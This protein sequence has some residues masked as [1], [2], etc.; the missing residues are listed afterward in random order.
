M[1]S[2]AFQGPPA[3]PPEDDQGLLPDVHRWWAMTGVGLAVLMATIDTSIVNIALPTLVAELKTDFAT[4][5]WVVLSYTLVLTSLMLAA[6]RLGDLKGVKGPYMAGLAVF[7]LGSLLCG[8]APSVHWLIAFRAFQ[9]LGAVLAQSLSMAIVTLVFPASQRGRALGVVGGMV[10]S[11]LA[12]GPPLGGVLIGFFGW[13]AVFMVNL[14]LGFLA[15]FLVL[16]F[17]PQS[18]PGEAGQRFDLA[19]ALILMASLVCYALGMTMGQL[20]GFT[21]VHVLGLIALGA[22]GMVAFIRLEWV[23]AEPMVD[24]TLFRDPL[25]SANL[26]M[27]LL[28]FVQLG[29]A[30]VIPFYLEL[31]QGYS[32]EKAGLMLMVVPV[33]MGLVS[34]WAGW[35]SDRYG[36]RGISILGLAVL[37]LGALAVTTLQ[38]GVSVWGYLLRLTPLGL[39]MGL[40]QSPNNSAIMGRV[41]RQHLGVASGLLS[42]SRTLGNTSGLPLMG[43]VFS[44]QVLASAHLPA[45]SAITQ[46]PASALVAGLHGTY[47]VAALMALAAMCLAIWAWWQDRQESGVVD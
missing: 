9:G 3:A 25:F 28:T 32:I 46:A 2:P 41:P 43:A 44:A 1:P 11:G 13:R 6:A 14:P 29:G 34:P 20:R 16:R 31:V 22:V 19:G 30:F 40:F 36:S 39:G 21:E 8:L 33:S 24:L 42:L 4:V 47:R 23:R 38:Q 10:A 26:V 27:G 45:R 5:Q 35:L 7:T 37:C 15:M 12:L 17:V 18:P